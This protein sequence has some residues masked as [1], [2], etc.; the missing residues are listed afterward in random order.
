MIGSARVDADR[1]R[2]AI[3]ESHPY[4][5]VGAYEDTLPHRQ[6]RLGHRCKIPN[7]T[8]SRRQSRYPTS[9]WCTFLYLDVHHRIATAWPCPATI[10]IAKPCGMVKH[11]P[12]QLMHGSTTPCPMANMAPHMAAW[13]SGSH[14]KE[15]PDSLASRILSS[16]WANRTPQASMTNASC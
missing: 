15:V 11:D 12:G 5:R 1:A 8:S 7:S 13:Q 9:S 3:R 10:R 4:K 14:H 2:T 6:F 16:Q